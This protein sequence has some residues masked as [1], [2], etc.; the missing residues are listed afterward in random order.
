MASADAEGMMTKAGAASRWLEVAPGLLAFSGALAA[1]FDRAGVPQEAGAWL[2]ADPPVLLEALRAR[3]LEAFSSFLA[4]G[5]TGSLRA[6]AAQSGLLV[7]MAA[8]AAGAY[9]AATRTG[10]PSVLATAMPA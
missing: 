1:E 10:R 6:H 4:A 9:E 2:G 8:A 3:A 7:F 5:E